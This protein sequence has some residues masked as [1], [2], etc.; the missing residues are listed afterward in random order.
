VRG[1]SAGGSSPGGGARARAATPA[2]LSHLAAALPAAATAE[3]ALEPAQLWGEFVLQVSRSMKS[4]GSFLEQARPGALGERH[5]SI[6]V[7]TPFQL[8]MLDT[9]EHLRLMGETLGKLTGRARQI[10]LELAA[11]GGAV[12]ERISAERADE[13]RREQALS[14][15]ADNPLIQD[16]LQRFDGELLED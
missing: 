11:A 6:V 13:A 14:D 8:A 3:R 16:L 10:R 2:S 1:G 5:Y 7:Q 4:L 15:H 12:P 9:P